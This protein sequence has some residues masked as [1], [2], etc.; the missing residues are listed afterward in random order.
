MILACRLLL[1]LKQVFIA[2][3]HEF[4]LRSAPSPASVIHNGLESREKGDGVVNSRG[5]HSPSNLRQCCISPLFQIPSFFRKNSQTPPS[6]ENF[7]NFTFFEKISR[8][9]S[10]K[11]SDD[12]FSHRLKISNFYNIFDLSVIFPLFRINF[13][14]PLLLQIPLLIS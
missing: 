7:H 8:F 6:V 4:Q 13:H 10:A 11:I 5:V 1:L 14:F 9:S 12:L 3:L 2:T